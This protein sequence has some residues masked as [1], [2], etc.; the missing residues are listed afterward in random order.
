MIKLHIVAMKIKTMIVNRTA[1]PKIR[2]SF[3]WPENPPIAIFTMMLEPEYGS[4]ATLVT[5]I[6][7]GFFAKQPHTT[8]SSL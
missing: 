8:E 5:L 4:D 2:P 6:I 1:A 3:T 7:T